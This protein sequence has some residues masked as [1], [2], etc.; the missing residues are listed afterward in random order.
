MPTSHGLRLLPRALASC[1]LA[2]TGAGGLALLQTVPAQAAGTDGVV[3]S[4]ANWSV[5]RAAGGYTV[6][7]KLP[8]ALPVRDALPDLTVDGVDL[9]PAVESADGKTLTLTTPS[10][11]VT[12]ARTVS[13]QWSTGGTDTSTGTTA[14]PDA[15]TLPKS[16]RA[17]VVGAAADD[18]PTTIGTGSYTVADYDFGAQSIALA[19]IGGIRG[20]LE[21]R[22][23]LPSGSGAHPLVIFLHG[24]HS[25]CY[26]T[27][28]LKGVS[29]WPCPAGTSPILSYAGY[30]AAGEALAADGYTV[31]SVSANAINANDN[32]LSP[33]DGAVTRGQL[34]LDTLTMLKHANAGDPVVYHDAATDADVTLDQALSAGEATSPAPETMTAS[35]LVGTMDFSNIGLMG[36][37]RGGEGVV[38]AGT[39]NEGL[40]QP[41]NIK[42]IFALAPIDFTRDTLPD[43]DTVTLLPYCDG[44][45]SD[46]QGQHFYADSRHAFN[47]NVL[48]SDVWVMGTDHDFYN[49]S[50]TPPYPGA[51]DDWSAPTDAVCGASSPTTTRLSPTQQDSVGAA[52]VAGWFELTLGG[53]KQFQG[54]FDGSGTEPS[55]VS[56]FADVRTVASEPASMRDDLTDFASTSPL[57]ATS[58]TATATVC[59][60][61][62]GRTV[63]EPVPACT[64]AANDQ[65]SGQPLTSQQQPYWTPASFA[66]NV[67]LNPMTD[68]TWTDGTGAIAVSVPAA[69]RDVSSYDELSLTMSPDQSVTSGTDMTLSVTDTAGHTWS[70]PL[71]SLN[72]WVVNRMPGSDTTTGNRPTYLH[73]LVLQQVHVPTAALAAAGVDLTKVAQIK[74][75]AAVGLD[76]TVSG[77][78]YLSDLTF[79]SKGLGTP[80]VETWPTVNVASTKVEEGSGPGTADVA[81]YLSRPATTPVTTYL[82]MI[83]SAT[84]KVGL[85]M[86]KVTFEPGQTCQAVS[87]PTQGDRLQGTTPTTAYKVDVSNS[88]NAVLGAQDYGTVTVREDD[89]VSDPNNPNVGPVPPVGTQGDV[90][91]E[92]SALSTPGTLAVYSTPAPGAKVTVAGSGYRAG[93]SVAF[94]LGGTTLGSALADSDGNVAAVLTIP[95]DTAKGKATLSAVGAGS[96]YT[97]TAVLDLRATGTPVTLKL[98]AGSFP[99]GT[100]V[101]GTVTVTGASDGQ[102]TVS[103]GGKTVT[104]PVVADGV[105]TFTLPAGLPVGSDTVTAQ[106]LGDDT[107]A[108]S[109]AVTGLAHV[110]KERTSLSAT[111]S[112]S[113][114]AKGKAVT[115]NAT[116]RGYVGGAKPTGTV[117]VV[118]TVGKQH[119]TFTGKL[120]TAGK[121]TLRVNA[122]AKGSAT[123]QVT[124]TGDGHY[125]ASN[126]V[127]RTLKVS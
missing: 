26:N 6:N 73:K 104:A 1:L 31:V 18:D 114:V 125:A 42:S 44:D 112:S 83:G 58:G 101:T 55:S 51:S 115:V 27:T 126:T 99:Y 28:T 65:L 52:Y 8:S 119:R 61:R 121:A 77:G 91:D 93:E 72:P 64:T 108:P 123:V 50:W 30:D 24:R 17:D 3:A 38:T 117:K 32:Q 56:S 13:W 120:T 62:Y 7:L 12:D 19:D 25:A 105:A 15:S 34:V 37:S 127:S 71:S 113:K 47:D 79:D 109:G 54:M 67:P 40:A 41:W 39:L 98:G 2:A 80:V 22:I 63:P 36:H 88:T 21:G 124:Y 60:S 122:Q 97:S 43:V 59:A 86:Q 85:A 118:V 9:G 49:T 94:S 89:G 75:T 82:S 14:V 95:A 106:Y 35:D 74:L 81:V 111:L 29:G 103:A 33:D 96:G 90:C 92:F 70:A 5:E 10:A 48:R 11:S 16:E 107:L 100:A 45:V 20:E 53:A 66:P 78:V 69:K 110:T 76:G 102:V 57:V 46:Q 87:V 84:G 4:G 68:L 23:Y 116:V